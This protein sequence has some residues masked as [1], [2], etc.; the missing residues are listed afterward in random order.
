MS[1]STTGIFT[2]PVLG[3]AERKQV[4]AWR[5]A[6]GL[7]AVFA[8]MVASE[9]RK[10]LGADGKGPMGIGAAD[11]EIYAAFFDQTMGQT[12]AK[13][14]AMA[15]LE[16]AIENSMTSKSIHPGHGAK[17]ERIARNYES[18]NVAG[19]A[20]GAGGGSLSGSD[21]LGPVMLPPEV[22]AMAP[23]LPPPTLLK[24]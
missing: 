7:G 17:A 20:I 2:R 16:K 11:S 14:S 3:A 22:P 6:Q 15:P 9:M 1:N 23:V 24:E 13:S 18:G 12:L 21:R 4:K 19:R 8:G 5:A 10:A